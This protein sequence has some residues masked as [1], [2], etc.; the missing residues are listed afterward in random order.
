ME[1][2]G[3][4]NGHGRRR[5]LDSAPLRGG[6]AKVGG[7]RR[8][9]VPASRALEEIVLASDD[10]AP[11]RAQRREVRQVKVHRLS[12][13]SLGVGALRCVATG[14]LPIRSGSGSRCSDS[15]TFLRIDRLLR[16]RR[17]LRRRRRA[18]ASLLCLSGVLGRERETLAAQ[19]I[20]Q[21][22]L[23]TPPP[24]SR[25]NRI[26]NQSIFA[27]SRKGHVKRYGNIEKNPCISKWAA[28]SGRSN[29]L[30]PRGLE[31]ALGGGSLGRC[32]A[33]QRDRRQDSLGQV[34]GRRSETEEE[35]D[36]G[37]LIHRS[38]DLSKLTI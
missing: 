3:P 9:A 6:A 19:R 14:P 5:D 15:S 37:K 12:P 1:P 17:R 30:W 2:E 18:R 7:R 36:A 20:L 16:L 35:R 11:R 28:E 26:A 13:L 24:R 29:S 4:Q 23:L 10:L 38:I 31:W 27:Q 8:V 25:F 21:P 22:S 34:G 33:L 32:N